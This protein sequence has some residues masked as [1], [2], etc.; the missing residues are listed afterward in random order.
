MK[1]KVDDKVTIRPDSDLIGQGIVGTI[2]VVDYFNE[3][4]Q[5]NFPTTEIFEHFWYSDSDLVTV[6]IIP[7]KENKLLKWLK[8]R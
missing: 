4:Y 3:K 5:I 7:V 1:Y 6:E 2:I 8:N